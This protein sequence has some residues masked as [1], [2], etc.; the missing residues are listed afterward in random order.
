M[1]NLSK[2]K[3]PLVSALVAATAAFFISEQFHDKAILSDGDIGTLLAPVYDNSVFGP[4]HLKG[5][6]VDLFMPEDVGFSY[7]QAWDIDE[8][9]QDVIEKGQHEELCQVMTLRWRFHNSNRTNDVCE[10]TKFLHFLPSVPANPQT[11]EANY[12][13]SDDK[14]V[15]QLTLSGGDGPSWTALLFFVTP[16]DAIAIYI[17]GEH[18]TDVLKCYDHEDERGAPEVLSFPYSYYRKLNF[19]IGRVHISPIPQE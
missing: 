7:Y 10:L 11:W 5:M 9:W 1:I 12:T 18:V 3:Y 4:E 13:I 2:I 19:S 17:Y 15:G 6:Q 16:Q 14:R 8:S